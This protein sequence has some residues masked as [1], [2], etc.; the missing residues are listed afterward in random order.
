MF[1]PFCGLY[2]EC[3]TFWYQLLEAF[4][5]YTLQNCMKY[6]GSIVI[7]DVTETNWRPLFQISSFNY[8]LFE[9]DF[10]W[11]VLKTRRHFLSHLE[12]EVGEKSKLI[13]TIFLLRSTGSSL[14]YLCF[15]IMDTS[16]L[17]WIISLLNHSVQEVQDEK[18]WWGIHYPVKTLHWQNNFFYSLCVES[19]FFW[20]YQS[21]RF[22]W[23]G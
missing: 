6:Q 13:Q 18:I 16:L 21:C 10:P 22:L 17:T 19:Y 15:I 11:A 20:E 4:A 12:C 8:Y 5:L 1:D 7:A 14:K 9:F 23:C 2:W 3:S